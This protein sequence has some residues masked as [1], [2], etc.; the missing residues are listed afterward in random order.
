MRKRTAIQ[1]FSDMFPIGHKFI[2][3]GGEMGVVTGFKEMNEFVDYDVFQ[4]FARFFGEVTIESD[5]VR[6]WVTTAPLGFH[7]LDKTLCRFHT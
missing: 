1:L 4:T 3:K 7:T 5:A 6:G 2:H